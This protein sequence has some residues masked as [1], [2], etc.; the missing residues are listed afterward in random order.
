MEKSHNKVFSSPFTHSCSPSL[1]LYVFIYVCLS[2]LLNVYPV[3]YLQ[4][5][6]YKII[7]SINPIDRSIDYLVAVAFVVAVVVDRRRSRV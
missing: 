6:A 2:L 4:P 5:A 3:I 7:E 1:S